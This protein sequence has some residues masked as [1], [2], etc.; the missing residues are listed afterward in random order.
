[1]DGLKFFH[2]ALF[3]CVWDTICPTL[4]V[5]VKIKKAEL[6]DNNIT[7]SAMN[8]FLSTNTKTLCAYKPR[9]Q[10][11]AHFFKRLNKNDSLYFCSLF[12][13]SETE[14]MLVHRYGDTDL[15][16]GFLQRTRLGPTYR[17]LVAIAQETNWTELL[18]MHDFLLGKHKIVFEVQPIRLTVVHSL[19]FTETVEFNREA[20]V[21][22]TGNKGTKLKAIEDIF[23]LE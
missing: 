5:I 10:H 23:G 21:N 18:D 9:P 4:P 7:G 15:F 13:A 16:Q 2:F 8:L 3:F 22:F 6:T 11:V 1:V 19:D 12:N 17:T 20:G 14:A